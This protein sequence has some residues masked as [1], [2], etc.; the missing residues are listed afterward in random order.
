MIATHL[1][2]VDED[3]I[4]NMSYLFFEQVL[5]ELG[6]KLNF[7]AIA[8]YAGNSF[9]EKSWDMIEKNNPFRVE[10]KS[11]STMKSIGDFFNSGKIEI[12][13]KV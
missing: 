9:F 11:T 3:E 12:K 7:E 13:K 2:I 10:D 5:S 4:D 6:H 8:N 1:G